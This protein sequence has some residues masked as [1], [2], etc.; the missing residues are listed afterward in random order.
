MLF[1]KNKTLPALKFRVILIFKPPTEMMSHFNY[2][3]GL[4]V[5]I[6]LEAGTISKVNS[7]CFRGKVTETLGQED[8]CDTHRQN[9]DP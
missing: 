7:S 1:F 5:F 9:G 8:T 2:C 3:F 6:K 4:W